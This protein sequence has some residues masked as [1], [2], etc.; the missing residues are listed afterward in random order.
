MGCCE[1]DTLGSGSL[2]GRLGRVI[3]N[4]WE[5]QTPHCANVSQY[6]YTLQN[7]L[8]TRAKQNKCS[9]WSLIAIEHTDSD[10]WTGWKASAGVILVT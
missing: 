1:D 5:T 2:L 7:E 9:N 3:D 8:S 6:R 4:W 10:C